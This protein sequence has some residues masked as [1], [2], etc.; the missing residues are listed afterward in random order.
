MIVK[1]W[2]LCI[3]LIKLIEMIPE[4]AVGSL[5]EWAESYKAA[6]NDTGN[7][8]FPYL[9][10]HILLRKDTRVENSSTTSRLEYPS[11]NKVVTGRPN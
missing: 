3:K 8:A 1:G 9:V 5:L 11:L 7:P 10:I 2:Y 4:V 6:H